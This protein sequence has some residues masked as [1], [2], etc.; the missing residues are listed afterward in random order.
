MTRLAQRLTAL[1]VAQVFLV[2]GQAAGVV[3]LGRRPPPAPLT[4][5]ALAEQP[6][7]EAAVAGEAVE[8]AVG[9]ILAVGVLLAPGLGAGP[10][11]A[12]GGVGG[13][14]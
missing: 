13:W 12:G 14:L 11:L 1:R 3:D 9:L 10:L 7:A 8:A 4:D 6:A 2:T 5:R